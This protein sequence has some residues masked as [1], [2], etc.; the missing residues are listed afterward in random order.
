MI[1]HSLTEKSK[2]RFIIR[3]Q[4][5]FLRLLK[6]FFFLQ[7]CVVTFKKFS[8]QLL[9]KNKSWC[10]QPPCPRTSD[11]SAKSSCKMY[12]A[13]IRISP[14]FLI[15]HK[16]P[17]QFR[18]TVQSLLKLYQKSFHFHHDY[19]VN[20]FHFLNARFL[21]FLLPKK[22]LCGQAYESHKYYNMRNETHF[23]HML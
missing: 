9:T 13:K 1:S 14:I 2:Q 20:L 17:P 10:S 4:M 18:Q 16:R 5:F 19:V 21:L 12:A 22:T 8:D 23:S 6:L 11:Q 3:F 15:F 7:I